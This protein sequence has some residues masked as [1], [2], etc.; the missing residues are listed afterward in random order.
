MAL[1]DQAVDPDEAQLIGRLIDDA[2]DSGDLW[3]T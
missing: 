1:E 2:V 3:R